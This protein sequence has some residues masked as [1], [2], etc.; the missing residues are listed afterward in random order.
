MCNAAPLAMN[1]PPREI[2]VNLETSDVGVFARPVGEADET[3][4]HDLFG[5][6]R[7]AP[8]GKRQRHPPGGAE[9]LTDL[10]DRHSRVDSPLL[11]GQGKNEGWI[12]VALGENPSPRRMMER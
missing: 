5:R 11:I 10:H 3:S 2:G 12:V 7:G 1:V 9:T 6:Q 8:V 4:R